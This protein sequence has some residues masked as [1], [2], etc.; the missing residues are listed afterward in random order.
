M[1]QQGFLHNIHNL[2]SLHILCS[3]PAWSTHKFAQSRVWVHEVMRTIYYVLIE[4]QK[5]HST[6]RQPA[7]YSNYLIPPWFFKHSK[8]QSAIKNE[9]L[10]KSNSIAQNVSV[11]LPLLCSHPSLTITTLV[12]LV[13]RVEDPGFPQG[14]TQLC[15]L[16]SALCRSLETG[17]W[18][19]QPPSQ[20]WLPISRK[21]VKISSILRWKIF[22]HL[23]EY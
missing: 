1:Y 12:M 5:I 6:V 13:G 14:E 11:Y 16:Y 8:L 9:T 18:G 10:Y 7:A 21:R 19:L 2:G 15:F 23:S 17:S 22:F 4:L 3:W 20:W